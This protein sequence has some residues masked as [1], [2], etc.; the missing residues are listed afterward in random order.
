MKSECFCISYK[1]NIGSFTIKTNQYIPLF[2]P[3]LS[4]TKKQIKP[5]DIEDELRHYSIE[6]SKKDHVELLDNKVI[7]VNHKPLF[8]Y[9]EGKLVPT[10]HNIIKH[11][12]LLKQIVVDMG[13]V[14]FVVSGADIMRPGIVEIE[15]GISAGDFVVVV[16]MQ[17]KKPLAV[18]IVL[19]GSAEM[20]E[21]KIGKVIKN[22][23]YVGDTVWKV[24]ST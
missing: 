24:G 4:L 22:V 7:F 12:S 13:A 5:K 10:L 11:P 21:M 23:H 3:I 19:Y 15:A 2:H 20:Q 16:D 14:R 6:L 17:H 9:H 18:G 1:N 8:F